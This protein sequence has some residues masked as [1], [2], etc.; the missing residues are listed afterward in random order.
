MTPLT[1]FPVYTRYLI[2]MLFPLVVSND[3]RLLSG[4][5]GHTGHTE[6]FFMDWAGWLVVTRN[7]LLNRRGLF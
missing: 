6:A 1:V 3:I 4:L 2:R 7:F 5:I